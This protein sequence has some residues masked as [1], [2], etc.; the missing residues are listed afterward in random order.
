MVKIQATINELQHQDET[1]QVQ[2]HEIQHQ[3]IT[4]EDIDKE[5]EDIKHL[6]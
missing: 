6:S 4:K 5:F 2:A 1:V 3:R